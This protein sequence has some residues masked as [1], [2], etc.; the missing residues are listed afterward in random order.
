M[1][2]LWMN[3]GGVPAVMGLAQNTA[4]DLTP[5]A[6]RAL[7][8]GEYAGLTLLRAGREWVL[9]AAPEAAVWVNG[10][11]VTGLIRVLRDRD[12]IRAGD[13]RYFFSREQLPR[14][15]THTGEAVRCARCKT[16]IEAGQP[17]VRCP[18]CGT[19]HHQSEELPCWTYDAKCSM[20]GQMTELEA[21][22]QWV[23]EEF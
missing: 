8:A 2:N 7:G 9:V 1:A 21:G 16:L 11:H 13:A 20:C 4:Y 17:V 10:Q 18:S 5:A 3:A 15:E 6:P 19:I 23:P 12:E 22:F 14:V